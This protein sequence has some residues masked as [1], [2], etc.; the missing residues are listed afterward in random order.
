M[1]H[2]DDQ[3]YILNLYQR[4]PI[5]IVRGEG[6]YLIDDQGQ[7]YLDMFAG[8]AVNA[9]GHRHPAIITAMEK[10]VQSFLHLS[11]YFVTEPAVNL[12]KHLIE[13]SCAHQV[14]FSNSGTE[15]IEASLK[16]VRKWGK[17]LNANKTDVVA[18]LQGFHGRTSGGLALTGKP[19][20]KTQFSPLVPGIKHCVKNDIQA[21]KKIVN[22]NTCAIYLEMIQG[23]GGVHELDYEYVQEIVKLAKLYNIL[24]VDD[25]IQTGIMRT[26]KLFAYE[27]YDIKPDIITIAK[28]I[29]GGLPLGAMLVSEALSNVLQ[30]GEHGTTFGGNPMACALGDAQ[31]MEL[32]KPEFIESL[33]THALYLKNELLRLKKQFPHLI[34]DVR[35][36]GF[37]IGVD[38]GPHAQK[39]KD[40][41]FKHNILINTTSQ[42]VIRILPPLNISKSE[43]KAFVTAFESISKSLI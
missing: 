39:Y 37:M 23:E 16:L 34:L 38:V 24:I 27:Y 29:G 5:T 43:I 17:N 33:N 8:I 2:N 7:R 19:E 31:L 30:K 22:E 25:E 12:A 35:G 41:F 42:T 14:F 10:Q 15:A 4:M 9:L 26:G 1:L 28:A 6:S 36:K 11:N 32:V 18:L 21:L 13:Y 20:Y 40:E 3:R